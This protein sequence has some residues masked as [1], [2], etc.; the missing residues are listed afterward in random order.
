MYGQIRKL[1]SNRY[2]GGFG[3]GG[4]SF[5]EPALMEQ[6][7]L[8]FEKGKH[9]LSR[10]QAKRALHFFARSWRSCPPSECDSSSDILY[11]LGIS[12]KRLGCYSGAVKLWITANRIKKRKRIKKMIERYANGYGMLRQANAEL[13]D[14]NAFFSIQIGRY[15]QKKSGKKFS[16]LAEQDVVFELTN[17]YWK[18]LL[19]RSLLK[20]K[21]IEEKRR[22]FHQVVIPFPY[23]IMPRCIGDSVLNVNFNN[24]E[25][26]VTPSRCFCGSGL[27]FAMCC[28]RTPSV[29]ELIND[30]F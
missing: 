13:D 6:W 3:V 26:N 11:Y 4:V 8:D 7:K 9:F 20:G 10:H 12:L 29:E 1:L 5:F 22:L 23:V 25:N 17:D 15:L 18:N 21:T 27:P 24:S 19:I 28:G 2:N 16:T 14:R 30:V